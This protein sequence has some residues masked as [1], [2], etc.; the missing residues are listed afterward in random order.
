MEGEHFVTKDLLNLIPGSSSPA[1]EEESVVASW[2]LV[3]ST[4]PMKPFSASEDSGHAPQVSRQ[5]ERG[6]RLER[7]PLERKGSHLAPKTLKR[8]KGTFG[9]HKIP[10]AG[11][12]DFVPWVPP[13]SNGPP[14]LEEEEEEDGMFDLIHNFAARKQK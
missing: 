8:R 3:I 4:Q 12:E 2:E 7:L 5:S 10:G 1:R 9:R 14:D 6:S 13:I 11:V